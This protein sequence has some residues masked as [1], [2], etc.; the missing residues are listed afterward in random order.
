LVMVGCCSFTSERCELVRAM[1]L[2]PDGVACVRKNRR[3]KEVGGG[4]LLISALAVKSQVLRKT[5]A[6]A[7]EEES[8]GRELSP[9]E[10]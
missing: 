1:L 8:A 7:E 2:R 9:G 10:A 5:A 4:A 6:L 3:V